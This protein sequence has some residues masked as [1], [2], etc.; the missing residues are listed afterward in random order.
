MG[1]QPIGCFY[2]PV[3]HNRPLPILLDT[4][5]DPSSHAFHGDVFKWKDAEG[6][7]RKYVL[8]F[9]AKAPTDCKSLQAIGITISKSYK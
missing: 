9:L 7:I 5:R 1:I 6:S 3:A 4:H 2:D 8:I